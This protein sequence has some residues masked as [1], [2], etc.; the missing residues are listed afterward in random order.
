[1]AKVGTSNQDRTISLKAAV[2]DCINKQRG[3]LIYLV[4]ACTCHI[5]LRRSHGGRMGR[6]CSTCGYIIGFLKIICHLGEIGR[7]GRLMLKGNL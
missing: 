3:E 2:R 4:S 5:L 7:D 6:A 1:M